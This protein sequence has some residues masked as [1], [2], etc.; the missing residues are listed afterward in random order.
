MLCA[1]AM[2]G[3]AALAQAAGLLG[4]V[5]VAKGMTFD[6]SGWTQVTHSMQPAFFLLL[7][8]RKRCPCSS[9]PRLALP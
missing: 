1:Q 6:L 5:D 8:V 7:F 4:T 2:P 3:R 9:W